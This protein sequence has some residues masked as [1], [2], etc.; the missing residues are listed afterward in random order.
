[1]AGAIV[2]EGVTCVYGSRPP[3]RALDNLSLS[4]AASR[5][6]GIVG[7]NGAGKTTLLDIICGLVRPS[8][9]TVKVLGK[10]PT[11]A[12]AAIG[13]VPQE[14]ALYDELTCVENLEFSASL[15]SVKDPAARVAYVLEL[16]GLSP[17][18]KNRAGTLS[19]GMQRRLAIARALVHDPAVLILDEPTLGVDVEARHQI[20]KH[21]RAL[22]AA[23]RTVLLATNYLDEAEALCD[24]VAVLKEGRL[25]AEDTP[26]ALTALAGRC[27]ELECPPEAV[28]GLR[29]ALAANAAVIRAEAGDGH[30]TLHFGGEASPDALVR[31]AMEVTPLRGF[32]LRSPDLVE[33]FRAV[34][35][36]NSK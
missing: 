13:V 23:G 32:R 12:R 19:G 1:M 25:V 20:W 31:A 10:D 21:I 2:V 34:S 27:L 36:A 35:A 9:G 11:L 4:I 33:I 15:Y 8:A 17:R 18:A 26:A 24:T 7:P 30:V 5:I 28:D 16:V 14:T 22:R 29:T 3:V 6:T